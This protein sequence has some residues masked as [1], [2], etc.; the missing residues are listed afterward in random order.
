[1][2]RTERIGCFR[3]PIHLKGEPTSAAALKKR[4]AMEMNEK[5]V[6]VLA[7]ILKDKFGMATQRQIDLA[8]ADIV[9]R[10][11]VRTQGGSVNSFS[12]SK[13]IRGCRV[14]SGMAALAENTAESDVAY[15][16]AL[17]T[18]AT[19]GSY[20]VPTIQADE[21]IAFLSIGG[22][23]RSAGVRIWPMQGIQK[24]NVPVA[25]AAPSWVWMAQNSQQ[26]ATDPNLGQMAF[27]LKE[28]RALI[29]I[30]NQLLAV[31]VPAFDTLLA[32]LLALGAAEHED[33]A[34]FATSTV[35]GGPTAIMS[36]SG[37]STLTVGGSANGGNVAFVDILAV[38]AKA[39]AVKARP[40]FVWF[41]SPRTFYQR[42]LG[43]VDLN[44]RPITIPTATQG[45]YNTV[46]FSLMGWP[47]FI[48][49]FILENE[50]V[51]SG[52]NQSHILF[53]NPKYIHLAQDSAIEIAVST[54]RYF[55]YAQTAVRGIAHLDTGVAPAAGVIALIGV[56]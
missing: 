15:C 30:P 4:N 21:I 3:A 13:L 11:G 46:Q 53:S 6:G 27:D 56:N 8:I 2:H 44:S 40:P 9:K 43:L 23:A 18:G 1:M 26:T 42:V 5:V 31:S 29:A 24:M 17:S 37:I 14:I 20:L 54:E 36:A 16:K 22:A 38:L 35:S 7:E 34:I 39:A 28:R 47:V 48:T 51:G 10:T 19:P 32:E 12:L 25:T 45:L 33:T 55:D 49:P 52:T 41:M 50:A